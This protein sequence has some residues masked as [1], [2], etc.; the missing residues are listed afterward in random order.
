M[1]DSVRVTH[2]VKSRNLTIAVLVVWFIFGYIIPWNAKA[3]NEITFIGFPLGYWFCVQGSLVVFVLIIFFQN[4]FQDKIDEEAGISFDE[5]DSG[6]AAATAA[7]EATESTESTAVPAQ[8]A[9]APA[10]EETT[11]SAEA[12]DSPGQEGK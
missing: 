4:W 3:L 6:Q 11:A 1:N 9:A 7:T 10:T 8:E 2:W 5:E 12:P